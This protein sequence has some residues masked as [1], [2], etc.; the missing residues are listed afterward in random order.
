MLGYQNAKKIMLG[1]IEVK[2]GFN[3]KRKNLSNTQ[4][5]KSIIQNVKKRNRCNII[6]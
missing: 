3:L 2:T 5:S 6:S 4:T 1:Q